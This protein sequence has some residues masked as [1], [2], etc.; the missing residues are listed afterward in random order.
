MT[1]HEQANATHWMLMKLGE[2]FLVMGGVQLVAVALGG[3]T[4]DWG[5]LGLGAL[6]PIAAGLY[7]VFIKPPEG[8]RQPVSEDPA[9]DWVPQSDV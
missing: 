7:L 5:W 1:A 4:G 2:A 9:Q 3:L 8:Y 6:G